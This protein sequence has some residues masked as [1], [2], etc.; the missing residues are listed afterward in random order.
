MKTP[1]LKKM[2]P[3]MGRKEETITTSLPITQCL[4]IMIMCLALPFT[5]PYL[6]A[7]LH[8]LMELVIINGSIA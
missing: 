7:K 3:R 4:S 2:S 8:T 5:L 6:L 1:D